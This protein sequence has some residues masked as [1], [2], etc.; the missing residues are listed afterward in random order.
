MTAWVRNEKK[1]IITRQ[2]NEVKIQT[3]APISA[4][5]K[6][7]INN[8]LATIWWIHS[9]QYVF[10]NHLNKSL[11]LNTKTILLRV[12][13]VTVDISMNSIIQIRSKS[14]SLTSY[15][16]GGE[17]DDHREPSFGTLLISDRK[18]VIDR[19]KKHTIQGTER[20]K[21]SWKK[22]GDGD[23]EWERERKR[24]SQ[25]NYWCGQG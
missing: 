9:M 15:G 2:V 5:I 23:N 10:V 8:L 22:D 17:Y 20:R 24:S 4:V 14:V 1:N 16:A 12:W 13:A 11:A 7:C 25:R 18:K 3:N 6:T 21:K 19:K